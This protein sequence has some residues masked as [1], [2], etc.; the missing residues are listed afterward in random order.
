[1]EKIVKK[2]I[3]EFTKGVCEKFPHVSSTDLVTIWDDSREPEDNNLSPWIF[4]NDL[5]VKK[6]AQN[7][8]RAKDI[9]AFASVNK[10]TYSVINQRNFQHK[11]QKPLPLKWKLRDSLKDE[12]QTRYRCKTPDKLKELNLPFIPLVERKFWLSVNLERQQDHL[13][14]L[15]IGLF[16]ALKKPHNIT[17][18]DIHRWWDDAD[19]IVPLF[20]SIKIDDQ[21]MN[22][23]QL[24]E[25]FKLFL[26]VS[27]IHSRGGA[28]TKMNQKMGLNIY[29][30]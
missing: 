11:T 24:V 7:L 26:N 23:E 9:L 25:T 5:I 17:T 3:L 12:F 2:S 10:F 1:M 18:V 4:N 20:T 22:W 8:I 13:E 14:P 19:H 30:R 27:L 21:E 29:Q 28:G 16:S 6:I 15:I